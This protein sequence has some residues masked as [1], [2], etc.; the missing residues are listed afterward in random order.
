MLP[1]RHTVSV[2]HLRYALELKPEAE[3]EPMTDLA[4][5]SLGFHG[6]NTFGEPGRRRLTRFMI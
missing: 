6:L 3:R 5:V 2:I 1:L 4:V